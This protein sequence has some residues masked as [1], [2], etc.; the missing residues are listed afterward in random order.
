MRVLMTIPATPSFP[1]DM[2]VAEREGWGL[3]GAGLH[4]DG[5]PAMELQAIS[6]SDPDFADDQAA[7]EHVVTRARQGSDLHRAALAAVD[8]V[9]RALIEATCGAW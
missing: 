7:W 2:T 3:A 4:A 8:D 9:E 6:D 1:F 5:T